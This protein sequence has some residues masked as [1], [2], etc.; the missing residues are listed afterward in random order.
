MFD[1]VNFG[2][3]YGIKELAVI[4]NNGVT[5]VIL[6]LTRRRDAVTNSLLRSRDRARFYDAW[7]QIRH[8]ALKSIRRKGKDYPKK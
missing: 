3:H 6:C 4:I 8:F 2:R 1:Y 5:N 7:G